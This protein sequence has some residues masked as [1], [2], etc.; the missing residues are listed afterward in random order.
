MIRRI[1]ERAAVSAERNLRNVR[2]VALCDRH[3]DID[4]CLWVAFVYRQLIG[5]WHRYIKN[6]H[7]NLIKQQ[8]FSNK[9]WQWLLH[10][11]EIKVDMEIQHQ[12]HGN[13][14]AFFIEEDGEWIAEM[15]YVKAGEKA[16]IIDHTEIDDK[17]R[18]EGI[19]KDLLA[20]AVKFAREN[21]LK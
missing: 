18:G 14:G 4:L 9:I 17:L 15:T 19:G 8:V 1:D 21:G 2:V 7:P 20:E 5:N 3:T 10:L 12:V 6:L 11:I 16:F 13:R